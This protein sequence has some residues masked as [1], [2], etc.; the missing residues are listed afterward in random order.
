MNSYAL[1][2]VYLYVGALECFYVP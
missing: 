2:N 1:L